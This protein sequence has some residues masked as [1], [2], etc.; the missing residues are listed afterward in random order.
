MET[1]PSAAAPP[2]A[3]HGYCTMCRSRCGAVYTVS[4]DTLLG[5]EPD[6]DHPTGAAL[7]SK[8]RAAPE[9]VHD[10]RR[11]I[12]PM[13]RTRPKTD[14]DPGWEEITWDEAL[15]EIAG[16]LQEIFAENG[17]ESVGFS[18]TSPSG[19][20]MSDSIEWVERFIR[21]FGSPNTVYSTE[22]CNW[23]KDH[24]HAFTFGRGMPAADYAQAD[25]ILLWGHNPARSWLAQSTAIGEARG[26]GARVAVI[27]PRRAGSAQTADMW[28]R[29]RPGT[30]GALAL[31]L[32]H[33]LIENEQY[34][35][36]F[37]TA[38]TNGPLL[39][40]E[41]TGQLLRAE[42]VQGSALSGEAGRSQADSPVFVV[43]RG[44]ELIPYSPRR[45]KLEASAE[46]AG[47]STVRLR[48]GS[49]VRC[50][51]AFQ[52]YA[53]V[54]AEWPAERVA[55][56]T[57]IDEGE[58]RRLAEAMG[59]ASSVAYHAW[60]GVGQHTNATQTERAIA[61][62]YALTGS[63]DAPGGNVAWAALPVNSVTSPEQLPAAQRAKALGIE[64]YPLGPPSQGWVTAQ[65]LYQAILEKRPYPIKALVGFGANMLVSQADSDR[66][67]EALRE[68]E[69][70][71][72]CNVSMNPTAALADIV[73]PV[74]T[75]WERE[76]LKTGFEITQ[77]A[78]EHVQLRQRMVRPVG[79]SRSD[80]EIVFDLAVR[81]GLGEHFFDG[82]VEAAWEHVVAPLD[83]SLKELRATPTGIRIPLETRWRKYA[84]TTDDGGI[85]GFNTPTGRAELYSERLLRH[86]Y[87]PLPRYVEPQTAPDAD[88]PYVLTST[89]TSKFRHTQDRGV[90]S[91]RRRIPEPTASISPALAAEKGIF[92]G[93]WIVLSTRHG[94]IRMKAA[95]EEELHPG[96]VVSEYGWWQAAPDLGLP[97]YDPLSEEGSNYNRLVDGAH[98]DPI[99]GS[100]PLKS[101]ACTV[102][103]DTRRNRGRWSGRTEAHV[104][105]VTRE[106][107]DTASLVLARPGGVPLP[108][109]T[110]GEHITVHT[111]PEENGDTVPRSYSLSGA[112]GGD[113][114][115]ITVRAEGEVSRHLTQEVRPGDT[116]EIE[117][118]GGRF[119]LPPF[120]DLPV[121]LIAGGTGITPFVSYLETMLEQNPEAEIHLFYS[122]RDGSNHIFGQRLRALAEKMPGLR[123]TTF[124]TRPREED[125]TDH[126]YDHTGRITADV[127][128]R[129]LLARRARFYLCGPNPLME[130]LREGLQSRGVPRFDIFEERF[131]APVSAW[132]PDPSA[133]HTVLFRRSGRS[134]VWQP[135]DGSLL[136]LAERH[137]VPISGGCRAGQCESCAVPV[138]FGAV[139]YY[140]PDV[141]P[142]DEDSC[143]TCQ[144]VPAG[145]LVLD[146]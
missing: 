30:D 82:S 129:D 6:R 13:R 62:L 120:P 119:R 128:P 31:G 121:V 52:L 50:R 19:T 105:S 7:C 46:L 122:S 21:A 141:D 36:E 22:I 15:T 14:S 80:T 40:R 109:F 47:A 106:T 118:P 126:D 20:P 99:S 75:P 142:D 4:G 25:L 10:P 3:K 97:S 33:L 98:R 55:K 127:V 2:V 67:A 34:D 38:W 57:W 116:V 9:L 32:A 114:Y 73:L 133:R 85:T 42:D 130:S 102:E 66:G 93:D 125:R 108:G 91:L 12:R 132:E 28:L 124:F 87:D 103:P 44:A 145:E 53:E 79:E 136:D 86:G 39:V 131:S 96:V 56:V 146:A 43:R 16:R 135:S 48:D 64:E 95:L 29:V 123:L 77:R 54:C 71:V 60:S 61:S 137:G 70:H 5:V 23:H 72:H 143:L 8:G 138:V 27:D 45:E 81:L 65:H 134:L 110:A 1:T 117:A 140:V 144:A 41:D 74:N 115:R 18:V 11:I 139:R 68:L 107:P 17:A 90:T 26:R 104:L 63:Y 88:F 59:S 84:Q 111:T 35:E 51:P 69:F 78:Q 49:S 92:S 89:K 37:V 101:V 113:S 112:P 100:T 94:N 76:A 24:A 83:L 58:I